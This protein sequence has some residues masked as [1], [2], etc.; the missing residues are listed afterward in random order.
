MDGPCKVPYKAVSLAIVFKLF[1]FFSIFSSFFFF[2]FQFNF[3]F[4]SITL[5]YFRDLSE[6]NFNEAADSLLEN[7][8]V[9]SWEEVSMADLILVLEHVG[10]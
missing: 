5:Y 9:A 7:D 3:Q 6:T 10:V 8:A 4:F 1:V 2:N